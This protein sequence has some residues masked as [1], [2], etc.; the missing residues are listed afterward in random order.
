MGQQRGR[1]RSGELT[2]PRG[3]QWLPGKLRGGALPNSQLMNMLPMGWSPELYLINF[4][5]P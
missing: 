1:W 4:N 3:P 5:V 2:A